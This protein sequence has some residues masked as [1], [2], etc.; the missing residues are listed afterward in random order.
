MTTTRDDGHAPTWF[1]RAR[2]LLVRLAAAVTG[3]SLWGWADGANAALGVKAAIKKDV[4]T[5]A[6]TASNDP[7]SDTRVGGSRSDRLVSS[8]TDVTVVNTDLAATGG[9]DAVVVEGLAAMVQITG[10]GPTVDHLT[11]DGLDGDDVLTA[12]PGAHARILITQLP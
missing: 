7:F 6:R 12:T 5:V 1:L 4:L 2:T 3:V 11:V 10:A 8:G 9:G